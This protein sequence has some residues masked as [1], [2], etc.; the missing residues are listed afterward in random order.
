MG[1]RAWLAP[2]SQSVKWGQNTCLNGRGNP[3]GGPLALKVLCQRG[4]SLPSHP[5]LC[6][7]LQTCLPSPLSPLQ[8]TS[9]GTRPSGNVFLCH[10]LMELEAAL[11]SAQLFRGS[12]VRVVQG[13]WVGSIRK[14][15][16]ASGLP[17]IFVQHI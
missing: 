15:R 3:S 6:P 11:K 1:E 12:E 9:G 4:L 2:F 10:S 16:W 17:F 8:A 13:M 7:L 14:C 5:W